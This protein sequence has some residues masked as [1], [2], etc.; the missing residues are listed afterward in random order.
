MIIRTFKSLD[1]EAILQVFYEAV[2]TTGAKYYDQEQVNTWAPEDGLDKDSWLKSLS[3]N[4]TYVVELDGKIVGF[5]DMTH[6][7]YID[8]LYVLKNYQGQG[9]ALAILKKLEE[10]AHRL[11]LKELTTEASIMAMPLAKRQGYEVV[12]EQRKVYRGKE[13]INYIMRKNLQNNVS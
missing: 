7:G 9:V 4:I 13:F 6:T 10:E 3:D 8:R 11:D 5:G 12:A 2:H 1:L